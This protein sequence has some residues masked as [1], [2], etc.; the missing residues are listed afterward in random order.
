MNRKD[1]INNN[2]FAIIHEFCLNA[3]YKFEHCVDQYFHE[4]KLYKYI[5]EKKVNILDSSPLLNYKVSYYL[6]NEQPKIIDKFDENNIYF[7]IMLS[8]ID[9]YDEYNIIMGI[10]TPYRTISSGWA[11]CKNKI[12]N[13]LKVFDNNLINNTIKVLDDY[14][15]NKNIIK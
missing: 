1:L 5:T 13:T 15:H 4:K 9:S 6:F 14:R 10:N 12:P 7:I 2:D 11:Y 8:K 3:C